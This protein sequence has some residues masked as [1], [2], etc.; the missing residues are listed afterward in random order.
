MAYDNA[1]LISLLAQRG[2]MITNEKW[3]K[4]REIDAQINE[5][6]NMKID[7]WSRPC[8]VFITFQLEEGIQRALSM[9]EVINENPEYAYLNEWFGNEAI[10][11]QP[12]SEPSD[13]I[14]EHRHFTPKERFRKAVCVGLVVF[15]MLSVSFVVIFA[16]QLYAMNLMSIYPVVNC[17]EFSIYGSTLPELALDEYKVNT[18]KE[19]NG[20]TVS[21]SGYLQCYCADT[22]ADGTTPQDYEGTNICENYWYFSWIV[23]AVTNAVTFFIVIVNTI[24]KG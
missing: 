16:A 21:Y 1:D 20:E 18:Q 8:S 12:A 5:K 2:Q 19:A 11:I 14:W 4:M 23:L 17:N 22:V 15:L 7:E 9:D 3:D 6:K 10:E 24:I 13:I